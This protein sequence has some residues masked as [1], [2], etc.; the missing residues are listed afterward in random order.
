MQSAENQ[1]ASA[2]T[3]ARSLST[4]NLSNFEATSQKITASL[5]KGGA[6][7]DKSFS[8]VANLDTGGVLSHALQ[9][10]PSC[11]FLQGASS[12]GGSTTSTG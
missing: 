10:T 6:A 12:A 3:T 8:D 7:I 1:F 11:A 4:S 2:A 9:A 5:N